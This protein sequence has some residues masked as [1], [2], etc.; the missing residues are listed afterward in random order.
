MR[1]R[2]IKPKQAVEDIRAGLDDQALMEK[3]KLSEKGLQNLFDELAYL[4]F[5]TQDEHREVKPPKRKISAG[6]FVD[7]VRG[8]M[9]QAAIMEKY[10]LSSKGLV[11][12]YRKLVDVGI[13]QPDEVP[14]QDPDPPERE[15]EESLEELREEVRCF[16]DFELPV[17]DVGAADTQGR[18]RDITVKGLGVIGIPAEV[19]ELKTFMVYH[20]KFALIKPFLIE[21]TCRWVKRES[22]NGHYIAGFEITNTSEKDLQQLR[23]LVKIIRLC[24]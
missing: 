16:L 18:V 14:G 17:I 21:A 2:D 24:S 11:S 10:V 6:E 8:G 13:L 3:Y 15:K 20:E 7:D 9:S 5:I 23:K 1:A 19:N 22:E 4:G 12:A